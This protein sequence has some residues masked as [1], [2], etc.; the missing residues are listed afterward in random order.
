MQL[1]GSACGYQVESFTLLRVTL[2]GRLVIRT[3]SIANH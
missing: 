3:G 2:P 1:G